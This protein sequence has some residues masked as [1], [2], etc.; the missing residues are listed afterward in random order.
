MQHI[1]IHHCKLKRRESCGIKFTFQSPFSKENRKRIEFILWTKVMFGARRFWWPFIN[2]THFPPSFTR[3]M[4]VSS[5]FFDVKSPSNFRGIT[6]IPCGAHFHARASKTSAEDA[7]WPNAIL[8]FMVHRDALFNVFLVYY[9]KNGKKLETLGE[10]SELVIK[11]HWREEFKYSDFM[12][13]FSP[14]E[15]KILTPSY[16]LSVI[17]CFVF[18]K[19]FNQCKHSF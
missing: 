12:W 3:K 6:C 9:D 8:M 5:Y 7:D 14:L 4:C 18:E 15:V 17:T 13:S 1:I 2:R 16:Q 10:L 11:W 19:N